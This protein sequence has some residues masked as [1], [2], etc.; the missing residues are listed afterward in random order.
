MAAMLKHLQIE[1]DLEAFRVKL[2]LMSFELTKRCK[3]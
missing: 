1:S 3:N 2:Y